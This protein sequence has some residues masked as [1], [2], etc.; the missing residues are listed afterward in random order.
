MKGENNEGRKEKGK[1]KMT[2]IQTERR[3]EREKGR[4]RG[5]KQE[6]NGKKIEER[7]RR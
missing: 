1:R 6:D 7:S 3:E 4:Y 5:K 2:E